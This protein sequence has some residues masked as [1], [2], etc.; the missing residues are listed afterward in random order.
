MMRYIYFL[1]V[2]LRKLLCLIYVIYY[3]TLVIGGNYI[4]FDIQERYNLPSLY[5]TKDMDYFTKFL[6]LS[7]P[8]F[9][10]YTPEERLEFL[11]NFDK[12]YREAETVRAKHLYRIG[13]IMY[14]DDKYKWVRYLYHIPIFEIVVGA[15]LSIF[16]AAFT[17]YSV[18]RVERVSFGL[19]EYLFILFQ[20][21]SWI[22]AIIAF[23]FVSIIK[24][25]GFALDRK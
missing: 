7:T 5:I 16:L 3:L 6:V 17:K 8:R 22:Q 23:I 21:L 9:E 19:Q 24:V 10:P 18:Y 12:Y 1:L 25:F 14:T 2:Y 20:I 11:N 13:R 15:W 4:I